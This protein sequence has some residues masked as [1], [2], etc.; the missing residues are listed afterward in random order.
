MGTTYLGV[1]GLMVEFDRL[2]FRRIGLPSQSIGDKYGVYSEFRTSAAKTQ[3]MSLFLQAQVVR[4]RLY[5]CVHPLRERSLG[6]VSWEGKVS[7]H[8]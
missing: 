4:S 7:P 6:R 1:T 2:Q 5:Y 3:S 8:A